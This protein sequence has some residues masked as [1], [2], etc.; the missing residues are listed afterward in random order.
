LTDVGVRMTVS[1]SQRG[2][3]KQYISPLGDP[4]RPFQDTAA[5]ATCP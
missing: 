2:L 1:D 4:F 3:V 5:F